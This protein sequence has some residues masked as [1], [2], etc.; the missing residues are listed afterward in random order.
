[1]FSDLSHPR[2]YYTPNSLRAWCQS[3][4]LTCY[5]HESNLFGVMAGPG[6]GPGPGSLWWKRRQTIRLSPDWEV[7]LSPVSPNTYTKT[8]GRLMLSHFKN[9]ALLFFINLYRHSSVI[10]LLLVSGD[11]QYSG[12]LMAFLL[13]LLDYLVENDYF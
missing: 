2:V 1:M 5:N 13:T 9:D 6:P 3:C 11:G 4:P 10:V 8:S 12:K 7:D